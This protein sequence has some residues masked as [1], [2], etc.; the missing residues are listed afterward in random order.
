MIIRLLVYACLKRKGE[1]NAISI[2]LTWLNSLEMIS[3]SCRPHPSIILEPRV[4]GLE[5]IIEDT[6]CRAHIKQWYSNN[7]QPEIFEPIA[8]E[9]A[10]EP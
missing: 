3:S 10:P 5:I 7:D 4:N 8:P 6:D 9:L 1:C 2:M